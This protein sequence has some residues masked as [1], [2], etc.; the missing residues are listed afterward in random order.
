MIIKYWDNVLSE[1]LLKSVKEEL[2]TLDW[3]K[4]F[5]R[6]GSDMIEANNREKLPVLDSMY[7]MFS[8]PSFLEYMEELLNVKG[9]ILDPY[10]HGG[11]YSQIK[12]SGDLKP[13]IDFNWNAKIKMYRVANF[14]IYLN[15]P[16]S[17]GDIEFL[18]LDDSILK[19]VSVK[20]NRAILFQHSE[21]I[22]H[23]VNPV[24]GIRN[25]V[26][27]FYYTSGL[28]DPEEMHRSLYKIDDGLP[29]DLVDEK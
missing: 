10:L 21:T 22:R 1:N 3:E 17:G 4:H 11:G 25:A 8:E 9:L 18:E 16:E 29:V 20:E 5:T 19:K 27:F 6:A 24:K 28:K 23:Y 15:T 26:R 14:I 13:H 12:N 7:S 2:N